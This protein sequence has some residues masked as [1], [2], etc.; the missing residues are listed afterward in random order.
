MCFQ[1]VALGEGPVADAA[2][3]GFVS[4]VGPHVD[5]QVFPSGAFLPTL[6]AHK[7]L[8]AQVD[9]DVAVQVG[10]LLEAPAALGA[11]VRR[12]VGVDP[13]VLL[14]VAVEPEALGADG[15]DERPDAAVGLQVSHQ[16]SLPQERPAADVAQERPVPLRVRLGVDLQRTLELEAL[17]ADVTG[18]LLVVG[19]GQAV[20]GHGAAKAER[21]VAD[22]ADVF[23]LDRVQLFVGYEV[24]FQA[25]C[26]EADVTLVW[27][28]LHMQPLV[29]VQGGH[30]GEGF[31][32]DAAFEPTLSGV[33]GLVEVEALDGD[34]RLAAV[35]AA[36]DLLVVSKMLL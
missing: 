35:L 5:L 10:L 18:V 21:P 7:P 22:V 1:T 15:A 8:D 9:L 4:I 11:L 27:L 12:L 24:R 31:T 29:V 19:V 16:R 17:P 13:H 34:E 36:V 28:V 23:F 30:V 2:L 26:L 14:Q 32:A 25:E 3:V 6:G 20:L 33:L